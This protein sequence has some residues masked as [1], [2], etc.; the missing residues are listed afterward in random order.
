MNYYLDSISKT[1][2]IEKININIEKKLIKII[3]DINKSKSKKSGNMK[4]YYTNNLDDTKTI[5]HKKLLAQDN[6]NH[7][8]LYEL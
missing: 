1:Y 4:L 6:D 3:V 7:I 8:W 2:H 5:K